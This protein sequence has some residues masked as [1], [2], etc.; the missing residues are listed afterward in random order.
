VRFDYRA[1]YLR[2]R[3]VADARVR[4]VNFPDEEN[5]IT[6]LTGH[7]S[8]TDPHTLQVD[9]AGGGT[10]TVTFRHAIIA[11]GATTKLLPGT[12]LS[13]RV[14]TYEEQI[15]RDRLPRSII[16]AGAGAIGVEFAHVLH[17]Y[18]VSVT[19]VE[20][21]DRVLPTED[22]DVSAELARRYRRYGI[23]VLTSTRVENIDDTGDTVRVTVTTGAEQRVLE[24]DVVL[25]A[26]GFSPHTTGYGLE[27]TGVE[28]TDRGAIMIDEF[29]RSNVPHI[30]AIG[31]VTA[32]LML[33]HAA[34]AMGVVAA[35]TIAGVETM[36]LNY[37]M[38]PRATFCQPQIASFGYTEPKHG[39]SVT[40][41][42]SPYSRSRPT[43]K[44]R[45]WVIQPAS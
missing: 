44:H 34:E 45:V 8:F 28:L 37:P 29:C 4:G 13:E 16:I 6:E 14:R 41:S 2:S 9:L 42:R 32:K 30:L 12:A 38:I 35:E 33:A 23:S 5:A 17:N 11:T 3:K 18:G 7:G 31:A 36:P 19:L 22:A 1:A 21:L 15:L 27:N 25:Q 43:A 40:T 26:I 10:E 20:F 39:N 24:T